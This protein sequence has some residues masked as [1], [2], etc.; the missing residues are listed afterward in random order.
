MHMQLPPEVRG[1]L[2]A[3]RVCD[4]GDIARRSPSLATIVKLARALNVRVADFFTKPKKAR[5]T[6]VSNLNSVLGNPEISP[7]YLF[8]SFDQREKACVAA[9]APRIR[10]TIS[11]GNSKPRKAEDSSVTTKKIGTRAQAHALLRK[12]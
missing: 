9:R 11:P 3:Q 8:N 5:P 7:A 2:V 10:A 1:I 6:R 12:P 4:C